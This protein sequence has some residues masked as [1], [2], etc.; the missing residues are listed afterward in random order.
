MNGNHGGKKPT[1]KNTEIREN[2]YSEF[3]DIQ[4]YMSFSSYGKTMEKRKR[5]VTVHES[6]VK[7]QSKFS[8]WCLKK[9]D[10]NGDD[11]F[12]V[13]NHIIENDI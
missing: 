4:K 11:P 5:I 8:F 1:D 13:F 2:E 10:T 7:D 12:L 6:C 9:H 3:E